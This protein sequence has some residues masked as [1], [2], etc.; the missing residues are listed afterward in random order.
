[1]SCGNDVNVCIFMWL[2]QRCAKK[3]IQMI[4]GK[5]RTTRERC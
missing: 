5:S 4:G 2:L 1:M 3:V